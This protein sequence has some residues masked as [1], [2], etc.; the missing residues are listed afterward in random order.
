MKT[1]D[2]PPKPRKEWV[3]KRD[4]I[5]LIFG[6]GPFFA[7]FG[8]LA[9]YS[10]GRTHQ[11]EQCGLHKLTLLDLG[12]GDVVEHKIMDWQGVVLKN[13]D[14]PMMTVRWRCGSSHGVNDFYDAEWNLKTR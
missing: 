2:A 4:L 10:F 1:T 13:Q 12:P 8:G 9:T 3:T 7:F 11:Q 6:M 14:G 5:A